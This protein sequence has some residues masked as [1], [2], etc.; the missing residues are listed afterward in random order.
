[1]ADGS[2]AMV[3]APSDNGA[4]GAAWV[5]TRSGSTWSQQGAKLVG[6]CPTSCSG[7]NG[8]GESGTGE[9]AF[10]VALSADGNTALIGGVLDNADAGAAWVFTRS[11]STWSQQG[12]K[13]VGD[14]ATS[15]SGPNGTGESGAGFLGGNVA[16]SS[17]GST[18]LLGAA[19]DNGA[20]GAAWVF[21]RSGSTWSQQGAKLRGDCTG[22]CAA[23]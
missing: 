1:V 20:A 3:G 7:P 11:G 2:T 8:T 22:A 14:C 13:L 10:S 16:L 9:F 17:D 15:C 4:A 21:T 5:F 12:A 23:G 18:A 19:Q 6:D